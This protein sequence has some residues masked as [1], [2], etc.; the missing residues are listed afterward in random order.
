[1]N[2]VINV[3]CA[4]YTLFVALWFMASAFGAPEPPHSTV[5][6]ILGMAGLLVA[7][8]FYAEAFPDLPEGGR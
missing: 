4:F 5:N 2:K 3:I 7:K 8:A 6:Y 1:M